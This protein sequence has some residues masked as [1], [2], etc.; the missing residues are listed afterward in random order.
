M[1]ALLPESSTHTQSVSNPIAP[2]LSFMPVSLAHVRRVALLAGVA[3]EP[4]TQGIAGLGL[5]QV[6]TT[7]SSY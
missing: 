7:L 5:Q 3:Q 6:H 1:C 2:N 4:R